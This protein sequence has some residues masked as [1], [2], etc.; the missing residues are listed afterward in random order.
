[1]N[2]PLRLALGLTLLALPLVEIALL[3]KMG[4]ILGFW[5]VVGIVAG[6]AIAGGMVVRS[7]GLSALTRIFSEV[8]AGNSPVQSMMDQFMRVTGGTLL[9]LP[10]LLGDCLGALLLIPAVRRL[11]LASFGTLFMPGR[12][13][14]SR[15][16]SYPPRPAAAH[17]TDAESRFR[18]RSERSETVT[19][20]EGEYE[21]LDD[22]DPARPRSAGQR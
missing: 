7:A 13:R 22:E 1:M 15:A 10:G 9:I 14:A 20:I 16:A 19:I 18:H 2:L 21:R 4:G 8:Q 17:S 12:V 6:T 11:V 3:I 5:P